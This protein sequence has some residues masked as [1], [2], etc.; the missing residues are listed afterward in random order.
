MASLENRTGY[1]NV[2]FRF[3][4]QKFTRSLDTKEGEAE[5]RRANLEETIRLVT[6]GRLEIPTGADVATFLLSDGKLSQPIAVDPTVTLGSLFDGFFDSLP[7]DHLEDSTIYGM[8]VH[9]R[10][11]ERLLGRDSPFSS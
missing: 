4:G 9:R 3:G 11:F 10:H 2:V 8:K 1:I 6:K 7:D 5:R